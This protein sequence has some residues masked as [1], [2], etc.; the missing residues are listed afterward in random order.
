M[1]TYFLDGR[2]KEVKQIQHVEAGDILKSHDEKSGMNVLVPVL[3]RHDHGILELV[4]VELN[5]GEKVKCT[6][7]HK[8]RTQETGEMLPLWMIQ[9]KGLS[10]VVAANENF[11]S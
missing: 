5:T 6:W 11:N 3:A 2:L 8:F 1:N 10:I 9:E 4:E 7:D